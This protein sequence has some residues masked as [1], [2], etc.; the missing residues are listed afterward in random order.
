LRGERPS[1]PVNARELGLSDKVW[2]LLEECWRTERALRPSVKNVLGR[3]TAAASV[4]GTLSLVRGLP[5]SYE[6]PELDFVKSGRSLPA[7]Q[8]VYNSWDFV[9]HMS[10][11]DGG[12]GT[13]H[14]QVPGS[15]PSGCIAGLPL[16]VMCSATSRKQY[17]S[18]VRKWLKV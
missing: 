8:T 14:E 10:S 4:C 1:K 17:F 6:D 13:R 16:A 7:S 18:K 5:Q 3:I 2:E 11:D 9:D 15:H 12:V